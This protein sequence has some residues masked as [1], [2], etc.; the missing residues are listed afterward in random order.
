MADTKPPGWLKTALELGPILGFFA[1][2][3]WLKGHVFT[4]GGTDYEGF[5]VV[6]AGFIPVFLLSMGTLWWLTGH[7]SKMQIV[8]AVLILV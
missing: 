5:I 8:T 4:I 6:T 2:Y 1:A 3:L 7:L